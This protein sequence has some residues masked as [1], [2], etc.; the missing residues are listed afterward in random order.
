MESAIR[1]P[2]SALDY[3]GLRSIRQAQ[4]GEIFEIEPIE[5][6]GKLTPLQ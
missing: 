3:N 2:Q 1:N 4:I 6:C 5:D